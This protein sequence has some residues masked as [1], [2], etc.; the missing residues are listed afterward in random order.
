MLNNYEY[1]KG[2]SFLNNSSN[3]W[4][5]STTTESDQAWFVKSDG[6][7][8]QSNVTKFYGVRPSI[9][10]KPNVTMINGGD[11]SINNPYRLTGDIGANNGTKLNTRFAGEYVTLNGIK[12]RISKTDPKYTKLVAVN[13]LTLDG[14]KVS[15]IPNIESADYDLSINQIK[16]HYFDR[17]YSS[18]TFV[19]YYLQS[20]AQPI[21]EQLV[22]GDFCRMTILNTTAQTS[23]CPQDDTINAKIAIPKVGDMFTV[24][25]NNIYWTLN[26]SQIEPPPVTE[27]DELNRPKTRRIYVVP[28]ITSTNNCSLIEKTIGQDVTDKA[29]ILPVLV[30]DNNVTITGG[31]G[32]NSVPYT[33]Q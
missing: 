32:T 1:S 26:N 29:A 21:E 9:V 13:T 7:I 25:T 17:Q 22:E 19:G 2:S 24:S 14:T 28:A 8:T 20:W 10:L 5:V 31:N 27:E 16:L 23:D 11:G 30:V 15:T 33:L 6:V 4:L 3:F 18:N 12:F